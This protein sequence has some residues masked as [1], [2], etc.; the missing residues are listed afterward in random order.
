MSNTN[1]DSVFDNICRQYEQ[2]LLESIQTYPK[3]KD[4]F[5][6]NKKDKVIGQTDITDVG[7]IIEHTDKLPYTKT[8]SIWLPDCKNYDKIKKH[9]EEISQLV[10]KDERTLK[11]DTMCY[12]EPKWFGFGATLTF[13]VYS[14]INWAELNGLTIQNDKLVLPKPQV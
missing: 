13:K 7:D 5:I 10:T 14:K 9:S 1:K 2:K 8:Q 3:W 11:A 6:I 12:V 4:D